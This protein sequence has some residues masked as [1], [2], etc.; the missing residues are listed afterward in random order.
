MLIHSPVHVLVAGNLHAGTGARLKHVLH[1][2]NISPT[3]QLALLLR[4]SL[5]FFKLEK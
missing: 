4:G 2:P 1:R 3:L 5:R